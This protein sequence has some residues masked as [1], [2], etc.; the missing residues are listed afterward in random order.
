MSTNI[1][2]EEV[3]SAI[4]VLTKFYFDVVEVIGQTKEAFTQIRPIIVKELILMNEAFVHLPI[5]TVDE[6]RGLRNYFQSSPKSKPRELWMMKGNSPNLTDDMRDLD[7]ESGAENDD[8]DDE[9]KSK[10]VPC[11]GKKKRKVRSGKKTERGKELEKARKS[12]GST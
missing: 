7:I 6:I 1:Y 11:A 8:G 3:R 10:G 2:L 5:I 4:K 12:E 9:K